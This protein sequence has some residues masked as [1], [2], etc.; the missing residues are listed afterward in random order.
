MLIQL[1]HTAEVKIIICNRGYFLTNSTVLSILVHRQ[2]VQLCITSL[3]FILNSVA[4]PIHHFV[5]A[6]EEVLKVARAT[7]AVACL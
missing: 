5:P 6:S 7:F 3:L 2:N 4:L 1:T